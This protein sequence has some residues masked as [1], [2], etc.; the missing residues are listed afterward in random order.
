MSAIEGKREG[1]ENADKGGR[2]VKQMQ[3]IADHWGVGSQANLDN[4]WSGVSW[5]WKLFKLSWFKIFFY[6]SHS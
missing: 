5:L 3:K 4:H 1:F 2:E 6:F